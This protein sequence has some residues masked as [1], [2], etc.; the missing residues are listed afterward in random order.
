[1]ISAMSAAA[2]RALPRAHSV[3]VC[4][5]GARSENNLA[6]CQWGGYGPN[7]SA[8]AGDEAIAMLQDSGARYVSGGACGAAQH[9]AGARAV[10]LTGTCGGG[11]G[12]SRACAMAFVNLGK[13]SELASQ[14]DTALRFYER[15]AKIDLSGSASWN[16]YAIAR[17]HQ[18]IGCF[19]ASQ[20]PPPPCL[21]LPSSLP[22]SLPAAAPYPFNPPPSGSRRNHSHS[23]LGCTQSYCVS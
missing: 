18:E 6:V 15:A 22:R 5:L 13:I 7:T 9:S 2:S 4:V 17:A 21:P 23:A 12:D 11:G 14:L 20:S 19:H 16:Y 3:W 1:M 10:A 8:E